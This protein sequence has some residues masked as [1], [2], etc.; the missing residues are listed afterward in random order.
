MCFWFWAY[1]QRGGRRL[2]SGKIRLAAIIL[3]SVLYPVSW[4]A[5]LA[6]AGLL[7]LFRL[8]EISVISGIR[9]LWETDMILAI[10]VAIFAL[11]A[12]VL[13]M[14]G[15]A[16]NEL[17]ALPDRV[18]KWIAAA[19]RIA[20]ADVFLIAVYIT[21]S[22]GIGVGRIETAWGLYLFTF[23]I[24]ASMLLGYWQK[25]SAIDHN[26]ETVSRN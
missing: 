21:I 10:L 3:V 1:W 6:R 23:C 17:S 5:P 9:S 7:P 4:F 2:L 22:K 14:V 16:L 13:K 11:I 8:S 12:P 19:G 18:T 20:M 24:L 25:T 26:S 15:L